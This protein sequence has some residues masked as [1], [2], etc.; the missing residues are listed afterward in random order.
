MI[1]TSTL[2]EMNNIAEIKN[3]L[4]CL[5]NFKQSKFED[6]VNA[7][8]TLGDLAREESNRDEIKNQQGITTLLNVLSFYVQ[9]LDFTSKHN[10]YF[11][12]CR[13]LGNLCFDH[14]E[15][16]T[17]IS[18][19]NNHISILS[20]IN[21]IEGS[22]KENLSDLSRSA[23]AALA[24][25]AHADNEIRKKIVSLG[26][27]QTLMKLLNFYRNQSSSGLL[28][29]SLRALENICDVREACDT[30]FETNSNSKQIVLMNGHSKSALDILLFDV[31]DNEQIDDCSVLTTAIKIVGLFGCYFDLNQELSKTDIILI[32]TKI[33]EKFGEQF[34][35][36]TDTDELETIQE[37]L[38]QIL[39]TI[40]LSFIKT[41]EKWGEIILKERLSIYLLQFI[42]V[43]E[44]NYLKP[45]KTLQER[46]LEFYSTVSEKDSLQKI[47]INNVGVLEPVIN[48]IKEILLNLRLGDS[49]KSLR[50]AVKL[51]GFLALDDANLPILIQCGAVEILSDVLN[52][53]KEHQDSKEYEEAGPIIIQ[54]NNFIQRNTCIALGNLARND[55][56]CNYIVSHGGVK[57]LL[58]IMSI[59]LPIEGDDIAIDFNLLANAQFAFA[60]LCKSKENQTIITNQYEN[61]FHILV[62]LAIEQT[63]YLVS[64]YAIDSISNLIHRNETNAALLLSQYPNFMEQL[65]AISIHL[66]ETN[67]ENENGKEQQ[68]TTNAQQ[69]PSNVNRPIEKIK[70]NF[71]ILKCFIQF[72]KLNDTYKQMVQQKV[73]S[74]EIF[75]KVI[76]DLANQSLEMKA[77]LLA[78]EALEKFQIKN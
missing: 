9:E 28:Y 36:E 72:F 4:E 26:G 59:D 74:N 40:D 54:M 62:K 43:D 16:A 50:F 48:Q 56:N 2:S 77:S 17:L 76:N 45:Q 70:W 33:F 11:Q 19:L 13:V 10:L 37:L 25:F 8:Q 67:K 71:S 30:F 23:C 61:V 58:D 66:E 44:K 57:P 65:L 6:I 78:K 20:M 34:K 46:I 18:N 21:F 42:K 73:L 69:H 38:I 29:H 53:L 31:L 15:N 52:V 55:I 5:Q 60:N 24:N 41:N 27:I 49:S 51:I 75:I 14:S 1:T 47:L 63:P 3:C 22:M 68:E 64:F 39:N 12:F 7:C 32:L 35:K